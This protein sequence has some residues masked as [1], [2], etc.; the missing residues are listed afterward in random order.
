MF[1]HNINPVLA[2]IGPLQI[3]YYGLFYAAAF[4]IAYFLIAYLAKKKELP[5]TKDDVADFIIY[6]VIGV[7]LGARIAYVLFYNPVFYINSPF[8]IIALW[9]GGLSFHGGLFGAVAATYI[10]CRKKKVEFYEIADITVVP[11]A[12]GLALGRLGNFINAE[13]Y[14]RITNVSWCVDYSHNQY[15]KDLPQGCRH[16]SQVYES[17]KNFFIFAALWLIKDKK[18]PKGFMFWTFVTLYGLLRTMVEFFRSPDEQLGFVLGTLTM[19]QLLSIPLFLI[20]AYMLFR[21]KRNQ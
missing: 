14:G 4:V 3:R 12:L 5:L 9:H 13:L 20:G 11:V 7:V 1:Y 17:L 2:E 21:L 18:L 8:E 15:V 16:P 10:F 19:G 6:Q